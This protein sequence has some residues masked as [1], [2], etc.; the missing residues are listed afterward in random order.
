VS[1]DG[2][3]YFKASGLSGPGTAEL[4]LY[5]DQWI[6]IESQNF[7]REFE[8]FF[9]VYAK[10]KQALQVGDIG[11]DRIAKI[12]ILANKPGVINL[13]DKLADEAIDETACLHY[14]FKINK[15]GL[16]KEV[17]AVLGLSNAADIE[18][19]NRIIDNSDILG[20]IWIG[21][22]DFL[23]H[24]TSYSIA[25]E[26][27]KAPLVKADLKIIVAGYNSDV[28]VV[29]P[30]QY[31]LGSEIF[32][33]AAIKKEELTKGDQALRDDNSR[34]SGMK[35]LFEAQKKW[36]VANKRFYTCSVISG[37]C[38][39]KQLNFPAAIGDFM[40]PDDP[41]K[42]GTVCGQDFV[43]CGLDNSKNSKSFCYY[44][45]LSDGTFFTASPYGNFISSAAPQ[46][47]KE[48]QQGVLVE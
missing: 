17:E 18:S 35:M 41:R 34:K 11:I 21:K 12:L 44:A 26:S 48:C 2:A 46:S 7:P 32:S 40:S 10:T 5:Q 36:Y 19:Y 37:D 20:E 45:K 14:S 28:S 27:A 4:I 31:R 43:Y 29:A 42:S 25:Y 24:K 30:E 8:P 9:P 22:K 23:L 6:R 47:F 16:K 39:G 13:K 1:R 3:L 33:E 15:D 38:N